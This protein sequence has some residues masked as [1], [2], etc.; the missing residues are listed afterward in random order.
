MT[1]NNKIYAIKAVRDLST[2]P[3]GLYR[4]HTDDLGHPVLVSASG[5]TIGL[6]EAKDL[7]EACMALGG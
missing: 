7:V 6:K 3:V 4:V 5:V 2:M 1:F